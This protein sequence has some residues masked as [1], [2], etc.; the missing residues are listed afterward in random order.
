MLD[1][2]GNMKALKER[3]VRVVLNKID[4][5]PTMVSALHIC[6]G[7]GVAIDALIMNDPKPDGSDS[8]GGLSFFDALSS[9]AK[10]GDFMMSIGST[11]ASEL[12]NIAV[13]SEESNSDEHPSD[14]GEEEDWFDTMEEDLDDYMA[15]AVASF[16]SGVT[17]EHL[18]KVWRISHEEA[19]QMIKNTM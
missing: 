1:W 13:I 7:E 14:S 5:S 16:A 17:P 19:K 4:D 12:S 11:F 2:E 10:D 15:S 9:H 6:A 3:E 8:G 18:S